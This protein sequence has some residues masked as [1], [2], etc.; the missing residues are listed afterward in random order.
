VAETLSFDPIYLS[1][2]GFELQPYVRMTRKSMHVD[3]YALRYLS[4]QSE[5]RSLMQTQLEQSERVI[6]GEYYIPENT[7][8]QLVMFINV[9]ASEATAQRPVRKQSRPAFPN[10]HCDLDN[11][12]KAVLDASSGLIF[13]DDRFCDLIGARRYFN[14]YD[15]NLVLLA[16]GSMQEDTL[17]LIDNL[18]AY[19]LLSG[20]PDA[21]HLQPTKPIPPHIKE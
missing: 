15:Q 6:F 3:K 5:L 17:D 18:Y 9:I 13:K 20:V 1:L 16:L 21:P 12:V 8:F 11:L 4:N 10:H 19:P 7:P 14:V 2:A